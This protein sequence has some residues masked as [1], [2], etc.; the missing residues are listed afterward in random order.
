M[1]KINL[2][3]LMC[4][5][6]CVSCVGCSV[7][8]ESVEPL[9][10][11]DPVVTEET[12][13]EEDEQAQEVEPV[14]LAVL[15][16]DCELVPFDVFKEGF[17]L[18]ANVSWEEPPATYDQLVDGFGTEGVYYKNSDVTQDGITYK[19]YAWF[20]DEDWLDSKIAVAI[21]FRVGDDGV[22]TYWSYTAQ[23]ITYEDL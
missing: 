19:T 10:D 18:V 15:P 20:S 22:L 13:D 3:I 8:S 2:A 7:K 11:A 12:L 23:G 6:I 16:E 21:T 14:S 9:E 5:T 17:S 4:F 1:R